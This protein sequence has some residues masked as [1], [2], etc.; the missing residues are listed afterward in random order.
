MRTLSKSLLN[1]RQIE[2]IFNLGTR[3]PFEIIQLP[4]INRVSDNNFIG[5]KTTYVV[6]IVFVAFISEQRGV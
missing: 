6:I 5:D 1:I 3:I 2:K 4:D